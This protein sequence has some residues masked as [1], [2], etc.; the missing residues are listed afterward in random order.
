MDFNADKR[1]VLK[2]ETISVIEDF[3][4]CLLT[5]HPLP[6][7]L[8]NGRIQNRCD[9]EVNVKVAGEESLVTDGLQLEVEVVEDKFN[10]LGIHGTGT[11]IPDISSSSSVDLSN[12]QEERRG[13]GCAGEEKKK[14]EG[15][16]EREGEKKTEGEKENEGDCKGCGAVGVDGCVDDALKD[17]IKP[18]KIIV[19]HGDCVHVLPPVSIL[20]GSSS[21]CTNEMYVTGT[22][23]NIFACQSHPEFDCDYCIKERIWPAVV[24]Q[25]KRLNEEEIE[26]ARNSFENH[27]AKDSERLLCLIQEFMNLPCTA[28]VCCASG[29]EKMKT[30]I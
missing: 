14:D 2:A 13:C 20:L 4:K 16:R 28:C 1:F 11:Q 19:S 3:E 29:E 9:N 17:G 6:P 12:A 15:V 22:H 23:R 7:A 30:Q 25:R 18:F 21:T 24:E 27:T 10:S 5:R 8:Q 26:V